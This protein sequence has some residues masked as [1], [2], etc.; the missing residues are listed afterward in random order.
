MESRTHRLRTAWRIAIAGAL[1]VAGTAA[2]LSAN[3][4]S[5][6]SDSAK[7][8]LVALLS[9]YRDFW[10]P[11]G[12]GDFSGTVVNPTVLAYNDRLTVWINNNAT[13]AQQFR[14][15]QDSEYNN[16]AKTAYDQSFTVSGG[17]GSSLGAIYVN[18]LNSGA[19]PLTQALINSSNGSSGAYVSTS[20]AKNTFSYARPF[21]MTDPN[22]TAVSG[23]NASCAPSVNNASSLKAMRQGTAWAD[24]NGN[25]LIGRVAPVTD[26]THQFSPNDVPLDA[27]YG[28]PGICKGGSFPSGHTT[29]AYQAGI[30]LATLVPE[31][32]PEVLARASE[33]GNNRIV[34]GVH[35][36]LDIV[37]GRIDGEA[38]LAARWSDDAYRTGVLQPA[39]QELMTYL[40]QQCGSTLA[41]CIAAETP[42]QNDPYGGKAMPGGTAQKVTDRASAV[43][44]YT[45]RLTYGFARTGTAGQPAAVPAGASNLL[46]TAFPQLTDAQRTSILAQTQIDSG[47][48][49]DQTSGGNG[50][51]QRLN[52]AAAMSAKVQVN[53][54]ATVTVLGVGGAAQVLPAPSGSTSTT[55]ALTAPNGTTVAAGGQLQIAGSGFAAGQPLTVQLHSDPVTIATIAADANGAFATTVTIPAST[56]AGAHTITLLDATGAVLAGPLAV[57]VT[58]MRLPLVS[59]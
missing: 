25:L 58:G 16:N 24:A 51:W 42:Y 35:Y 12:Q 8:D 19:L 23:D 7:P 39:R 36:P 4:A 34:L 21:V 31:L 46:L 11:S 59:G 53:A 41:A 6:P 14:A 30:T 56:P 38:A 28:Q 57:T 10:T 26:T 33:N 9:G 37:G 22:A 44:V 18:G 20:T 27:A 50:S 15:L 52:L 2:P 48:P 3:A 32:G 45:E 55:R 40:Q 54:D 17:L 5:Y 47:Y 29:T 49:L 43:S 1:V 13:A